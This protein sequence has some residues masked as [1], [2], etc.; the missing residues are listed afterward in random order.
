MRWA[1]TTK[2]DPIICA[3][4]DRHYPR[5]KKGATQTG[6]PGR[7]L[8]L[9]TVDGDAFWITSWPK[10]VTHRFG[11]TWTC[12]K[13]RNEAGRV[14]LS[15]ELI[16]EGMAATRAHFGEPPAAGF[17][18]FV[19][20]EEVRTKRDPGRCFLRAGFDYIGTT[21]GGHGRP[22]LLVLGCRTELIPEPDRAL[23]LQLAIGAAA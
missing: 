14:N 23:D 3:L 1:R 21:P 4:A 8:A 19:D 15:S 12:S 20:P 17:L 18:T 16:L 13:F 7:L 5:R 2:G 22:P 11:A 9:R 6:Q 10:F